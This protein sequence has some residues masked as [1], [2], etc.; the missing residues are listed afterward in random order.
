MDLILA[1][2]L[3]V[4]LGGLSLAL[5]IRML[6]LNSK[7]EELTRN[8]TSSK[9]VNEQLSKDLA[10]AEEV[11]TN[12]KN[13]LM[14]ADEEKERLSNELQQAYQVSERLSENLKEVTESNKNAIWLICLAELSLHL[15]LVALY[16]QQRKFNHLTGIY[17]D[18]VD[19]VERATNRRR[20][21]MGFK[22]LLAF[23]PLGSLLDL[24]GDGLEMMAEAIDNVA[25]SAE[26]MSVELEG[27]EGTEDDMVRLPA[28]LSRATGL[29]GL[30]SERSEISNVKKLDPGGLN[31]SVNPVIQR[32][33]EFIE[34]L[35]EDQRREMITRI[36]AGLA[37]FN[38]KDYHYD[39]AEKT[40]HIRH[41]E[42]EG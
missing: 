1:I 26:E 15:C 31:D 40:L 38:I 17:N 6:T 7:N 16:N 36:V 9:K 11:E 29:L 27:L 41:S 37:E 34:S 42:K 24:L 13:D 30:L 25:E 23:V 22:A 12:L 32:V 4:G 33:K 20:I 39:E 19:R 3:I 10:Q 14:Q 35:T 5:L 8:F 2:T 21:R 18:L 28:S